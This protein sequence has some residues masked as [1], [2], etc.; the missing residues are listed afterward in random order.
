MIDAH[1]TGYPRR[2]DVEC[3]DGGVNANRSLVSNWLRETL[4]VRCTFHTL[5]LLA[6]RYGFPGALVSSFSK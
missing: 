3:T 5:F 2:S 1:G 4:S 6:G